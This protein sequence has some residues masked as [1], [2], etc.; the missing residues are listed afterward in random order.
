MDNHMFLSWN[1]V[2]GDD[3]L[4]LHLGDVTLLSRP[5][6]APSLSEKLQNLRGHKILIRGNHD[7]REML[8]AYRRWG[9][10][11]L[12][13]LSVGDILFT[14]RPVYTTE[15]RP[16]FLRDTVNIHGHCHGTSRSD[17]VHTDVG[18]DALRIYEP[19]EARH[20]VSRETCYQLALLYRTLRYA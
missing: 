11:V 20:F 16:G 12:S 3:D 5:S 8:K 13:S 18:V 10:V 4:V 19:V 17:E 6:K 15:T 2:V 14:H 1:S 7:R 9:W